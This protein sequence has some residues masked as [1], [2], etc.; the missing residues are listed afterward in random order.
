L[1]QNRAVQDRECEGNLKSGI[2]SHG[3]KQFHEIKKSHL[4]IKQLRMITQSCVK[5]EGNQSSQIMFPYDTVHRPKIL[6]I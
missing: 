4:P 2:H 1:R 3:K 6:A 5:G